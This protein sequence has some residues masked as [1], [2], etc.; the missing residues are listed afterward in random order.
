MK[1][2]N[3]YAT[4][5]PDYRKTPKAVYCAIAYSLALRLTA[6]S[7]EAVNT[8]V[9]E[10]WQALYDNGL[11]K[12]RP[13][14]PPRPRPGFTIVELSAV[15]LIIAVL[16]ALLMP[17]LAMAREEARR[18]RCT[19]NLREQHDALISYADLYHN[20]PAYV[21]PGALDL[22]DD[23]YTCPSDH[24]STQ[25]TAEPEYGSYAWLA[26]SLRQADAEPATVILKEYRANHAGTRQGIKW[27]AQPVSFPQEA[28]Q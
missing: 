28:Q 2:L 18:V 5:V 24:P 1:I 3:E 10:E 27:N 11:V 25:I 16:I 14:A 6:D 26:P 7:N 4:N 20:F 13:P 19:V 12:Q 21:G 22:P 17:A 23:T 9:R 8:I 15:I